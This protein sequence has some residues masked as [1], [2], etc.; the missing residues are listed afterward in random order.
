MYKLVWKNI[1]KF[2]LFILLACTSIQSH[3]QG[4]STEG[5][6]F[7][8]GFMTNWL[9]GSSNPVILELYI[10]ANDTTHGTVTMP[11]EPLFSTIDFEVFPNATK[12]IVISRP[13]AMA[14]GS[15]IIENKGIHIETDDNVSVYAMNKRQYSADM[16]VVLPTYSLGNNYFVLSHWEDGNRN[17]NANSDSE[18]LIVA[19]TDST[20]V[21]ITPTHETIN[22]NPAN[23]PFRITLQQGETFQLRAKGDLTGSQIVATNQWGCQNFAVFS[24]NMYTQVGECNVQN[25]HDHLYAQ[26]YPTNTLG[27]NFIIVPLENRFGGDILKILA[28]RDNTMITA[29][30]TSYEL[31][32]GEFVKLLSGEVLQV[33]SD[34]PIAVGQY[35]RTM[36]CDG[37]LGDPF[38]IPISPNEQLLKRI[39]F[40]A[41]SIATLSLYSLNIITKQSEVSNITF[42]NVNIGSEFL[43]VQ[44]S[45]YAFARINTIGGNHTIKSNDGFI[46]YVYGFGRKRILWLC[47][48]C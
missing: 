36:D 6:D 46:A 43:P 7:W 19:I 8:V 45:E 1:L 15:N 38:L 44:G 5:K 48:W 9:Q 29:N 13:L 22:G 30:E 14:T 42:D 47:N 32:A 25:G 27:K 2:F 24:G 10:S 37:T 11:L 21:E 41:P 23:V 39:T 18:F 17:N 34:K 33:T 26:M 3:G 20:E 4:I 35:S 31:D 12:R 28:T 40:N 16:T